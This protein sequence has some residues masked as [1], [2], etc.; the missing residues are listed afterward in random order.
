M[1]KKGGCILQPT[2]NDASDALEE[3][4]CVIIFAL[5]KTKR[6]LVQI[7]KQ[8][9][10]FNTDICC[11]ANP[12]LEQSPKVF[13]PVG[14]DVTC[15]R[16]P[17]SSWSGSLR[18]AR[19]VMPVVIVADKLS[20]QELSR[21]PSHN[22]AATLLKPLPFDVLLDTV[23]IILC[24][25]NHLHEQFALWRKADKLE[26]VKQVCELCPGLKSGG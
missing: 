16:L 23:N 6:L 20:I 4:A 14:V 21:T 24:A 3:S 18:G 13:K 5:V 9:K 2:S 12:A 25:A 1:P 10:R 7:A 17:A 11:P 26:H 22:I 19:L 15:P 8:M